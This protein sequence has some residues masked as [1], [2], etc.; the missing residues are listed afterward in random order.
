M[1]LKVMDPK[2]DGTGFWLVSNCTFHEHS[3]IGSLPGN[4]KKGKVQI[5][6][7]QGNPDEIIITNGLEGT[8]SF[9]IP[10]DTSSIFKACLESN[11]TQIKI[12]LGGFKKGTARITFVNEPVKE[13]SAKE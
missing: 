10:S 9:K 12:D 11:E 7:L 2:E 4:L 3:F 5:S 8:R 6:I 13:E 1:E